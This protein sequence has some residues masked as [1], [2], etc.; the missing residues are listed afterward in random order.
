VG[1]DAR[2]CVR[3]RV[4]VCA[5]ACVCVCEY[6]C[7]HTRR[8]A[9]EQKTVK[10]VRLAEICENSQ[11]SVSQDYLLIKITVATIVT[12]VNYRDENRSL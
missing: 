7:P 5:C 3:V 2:V 10:R 4:C 9:K 6:M 11:D 8:R 12:Y 1:I